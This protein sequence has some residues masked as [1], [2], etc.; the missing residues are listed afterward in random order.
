MVV[1]TEACVAEEA[2][3]DDSTILFCPEARCH[4]YGS[5]ESTNWY[6]CSYIQVT[7]VVGCSSLSLQ[8]IRP[9]HVYILHLI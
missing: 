3:P 6:W 8:A 2:L 1:H 9:I 4:F 5:I 7:A